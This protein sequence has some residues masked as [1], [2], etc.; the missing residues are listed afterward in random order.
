[1]WDLKTIKHSNRQAAMD[2]VTSDEITEWRNSHKLDYHHDTD[3]EIRG[4]IADDG[5]DDEEQN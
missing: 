5:W 4:Y 3:D 1:M 2:A